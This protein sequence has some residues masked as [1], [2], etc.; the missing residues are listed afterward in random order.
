MFLI[1]MK[2]KAVSAFDFVEQ[3]IAKAIAA[4]E[5]KKLKLSCDGHYDFVVNP[6]VYESANSSH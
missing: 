2:G 4:K 3:V 6:F 1:L 5:G